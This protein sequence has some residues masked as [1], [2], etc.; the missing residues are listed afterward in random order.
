MA[1]R[2][3]AVEAA[4]R[5]KMTPDAVRARLRRGQLAG[6]K[7]G[8]TWYVF[9]DSDS[10]ATV[11]DSQTVKPSSRETVGTT[12]NHSQR[13]SNDSQTAAGDSQATVNDSQTPND[14][15]N[16][17]Y[18]DALLDDELLNGDPALR[19]AVL[20]ATLRGT[21]AQ[22]AAARDEAQFLR[23]RLAEKDA[24]ISRLS[25]AQVEALRRRDILAAQERKELPK[26]AS[27]SSNKA[28]WQF[29]R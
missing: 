3:T 11:N 8:N 14:A 10:Q 15:G 2:V 21:L 20:E 26:P 5:L 25:E 29:W 4:A 12:V 24:V 1:E 28:W 16:T 17:R 9:L 18:L 7:Q 19:A 13:Q 6:E 23:E 22:L 27:S